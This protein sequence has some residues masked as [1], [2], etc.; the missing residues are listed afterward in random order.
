MK[1]DRLIGIL[2]VLLQKGKVTAPYLAEKFRSSRRTISRD[3][4]D[5]CRA[6]VPLRQFRENMAVFRLRRDMP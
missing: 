3:I 5:L 1:I 6:G 2:T 4:D